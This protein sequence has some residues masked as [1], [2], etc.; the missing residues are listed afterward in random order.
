MEDVDNHIR[1]ENKEGALCSIY[2]ADVQNFFDDKD[3]SM[4]DFISMITEFGVKELTEKEN[5]VIGDEGTP[6]VGKEKM[7]Q[8]IYTTAPPKTFESMDHYS[9]FI[10]KNVEIQKNGFV[11]TK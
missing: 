7:G 2:L 3:I 8:G 4:E 9:E 1:L 5:S 6:A 10:S 11:S